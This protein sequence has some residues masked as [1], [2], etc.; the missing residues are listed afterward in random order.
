MRVVNNE[1][2]IDRWQRADT[3]SIAYIGKTAKGKGMRKR[4]EGMLD[5]T[6][7]AIKKLAVLVS[8]RDGQCMPEIEYCYIKVASQQEAAIWES[9]LQLSYY[10]FFSRVANL[11]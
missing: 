8:C 5:G 4:S 1:G 9:S 6:H 11:A 10:H 2:R 3:L 7:Q